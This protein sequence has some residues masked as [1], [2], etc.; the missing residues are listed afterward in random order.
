[1]FRS[2]LISSMLSFVLLVL[3]F[4]FA[5]SEDDPPQPSAAEL[6][7]AD[8]QFWNATRTL[9]GD[10]RHADVS[11]SLDIPRSSLHSFL[12]HQHGGS[13]N[14]IGRFKRLAILISFATPTDSF[15]P[16]SFKT[17]NLSQR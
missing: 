2:V 1:M 14:S 16:G 15:H 10:P 7:Q 9:F 5:C 4:V 12:R 8:D 6:E 11:D 13:I 3:L 17:D